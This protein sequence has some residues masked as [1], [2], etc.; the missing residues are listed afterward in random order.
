[1][2]LSDR[3]QKVSLLWK[4]LM[5]L[6]AL[7]LMVISISDIKKKKNLLSL[8][9]AA[10]NP[11]YLEQTHIDQSEVFSFFHSSKTKVTFFLHL[12]KQTIFFSKSHCLK[13]T[14]LWLLELL[15][16]RVFPYL[17]TIE[18]L[19]YLLGIGAN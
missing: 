5:F 9:M 4:S 11:L 1:M 8:K 10:C 19:I 14:F 18:T 15:A 12:R 16:S 17:L 7:L 13:R 3:I 2:M 6:L